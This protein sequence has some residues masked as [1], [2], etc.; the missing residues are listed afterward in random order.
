VLVAAMV[1]LLQPLLLI[2]TP[3]RSEGLVIMEWKYC[4]GAHGLADAV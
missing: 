2:T 1:F 4:A 3:N